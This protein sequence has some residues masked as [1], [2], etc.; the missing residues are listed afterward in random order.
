[1]NE[2]R[3]GAH[4]LCFFVDADG[5]TGVPFSSSVTNLDHSGDPRL[6]RLLARLLIRENWNLNMYLCQKTPPSRKQAAVHDTAVL[7][8][9]SEQRVHSGSLSLV[10][11]YATT[12][13]YDPI[14]I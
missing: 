8:C 2:A 10:F 4:R 14:S 7:P 3:P 9:S 12:M 6:A 11:T 5:F 1:M 13:P